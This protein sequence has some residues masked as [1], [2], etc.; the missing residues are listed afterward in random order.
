MTISDAWWDDKNVL[1]LMDSSGDVF[2]VHPS[3]VVRRGWPVLVE[4]ATWEQ[5][6]VEHARIT[7]TPFL[8]NL[9]MD[10]VTILERRR[11][12][13]ERDVL[14][15]ITLRVCASPLSDKIVVPA[16]APASMDELKPGG[17]FKNFVNLTRPTV[18]SNGALDP[19][20]FEHFGQ[21]FFLS[22]HYVAASGIA[23]E[24]AMLSGVGIASMDDYNLVLT[25]LPTSVT[26]KNVCT[27]WCHMRR[28]DRLPRFEDALFC[29]STMSAKGP[30]PLRHE[31]HPKRP[32]ELQMSNARSPRWHG[33]IEPRRYKRRPIEYVIDPLKNELKRRKR[34]FDVGLL[35]CDVFNE[36]FGTFAARLIQS[37]AKADAQTLLTLRL[38]SRG[39]RDTVDSECDAYLGRTRAAIQNAMNTKRIADIAD[40]RTLLLSGRL[41][42]RLVGVVMREHVVAQY[43]TSLRSVS[44]MTRREFEEC[45]HRTASGHKSLAPLRHTLLAAKLRGVRALALARRGM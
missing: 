39:L 15:G 13:G 21:N 20:G 36:I 37:T 33:G 35:P 22:L 17:M 40:A 16:A 10:N 12:D 38:V 8:K 7:S 32:L 34:T 28:L 19:I 6:V 44:R 31:G 11:A 3:Y 9:R 29:M 5:L 1:K 4:V 25:N 18:Q 41:H 43:R 23:E 27:R 26:G 24:H 30:M 45:V 14:W 2:A 42:L